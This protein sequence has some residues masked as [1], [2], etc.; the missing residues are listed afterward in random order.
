MSLNS[1]M[2]LLKLLVSVCGLWIANKALSTWKE[3][4]KA[5]KLYEL[6][7]R[8]Y[9]LLASINNCINESKQR[10]EVDTD[11]YGNISHLMC[12]LFRTKLNDMQV[13]YLDLVRIKQN[14]FY[15]EYFKKL[16]EKYSAKKSD[17]IFYQEEFNFIGNEMQNLEIDY[18]NWFWTDYTKIKKDGSF[19]DFHNEFNKM[20][21]KGLDFYNSE[22]AKYY[23]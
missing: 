5:K 22:I 19:C 7:T 20:L 10:D 16:A 14:I 23:K 1:I 8:A 11:D 4:I 21:S 13:V 17:D 9:E 3:E 6:N 15:F 18:K 12:D 2:N